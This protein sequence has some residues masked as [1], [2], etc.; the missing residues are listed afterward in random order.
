MRGSGDSCDASIG[1]GGLRSWA[2]VPLQRD[3][4]P[5]TDRRRGPRSAGP[6]RRSRSPSRCRIAAATRPSEGPARLAERF[7]ERTGIATTPD[8]SAPRG[9]SPSRSRRGPPFDVFLA[10]NAKFVEDLAAAGVVDP[11]S[12]RPYARGIARALAV[13]QARRR[14]GPRPRRPGEARGQEDRH[15]QPRVRPLTAWPASRRSR[16]PGLWTSSRAE[17]RPGR[18]GPPGPHVRPERAT[19]RPALVG[20]AIA[21]VPEVRVG[22]G[23]SRALRPDRR[24]GSG[25]VAASGQPATSRARSPRSCSGT[26]GQAILREF[27]FQPPHPARIERRAATKRQTSR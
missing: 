16:R 15:G 4:R 19:P 8:A 6:G 24:R 11:G 7:R 25:V 2:C 22:R 26:E 27:G 23:R 17:D 21:D 3:V 1:P 14:Q 9:S 20:R 12:V 5:Q 18:V 10:A 13:H